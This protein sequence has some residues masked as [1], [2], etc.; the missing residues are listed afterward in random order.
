MKRRGEK[1]TFR[2]KSESSLGALSEDI[3]RRMQAQDPA[4]FQVQLSRC[5]VPTSSPLSIDHDPA[6]TKFSAF[7]TI[8]RIL[9][10]DPHL[11]KKLQ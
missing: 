11:Q 3:R 2:G 1:P 4:Y 5:S 10:L 8:F 6:F 7:H 9:Q